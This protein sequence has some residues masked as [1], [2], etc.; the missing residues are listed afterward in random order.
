MKRISRVLAVGTMVALGVVGTSSSALAG[1][2][3]G[4]TPTPPPNPAKTAK[5]LQAHGA[6]VKRLGHHQYQIFVPAAQ[7]AEVNRYCKRYLPPGGIDRGGDSRLTFRIGGPGK[8]GS[9]KLEKCLSDH[10]APVPAGEPTR[11]EGSTSRSENSG[12]GDSGPEAGTVIRTT[13]GRSVTTEKADPETLAA[14]KACA[15]Y[16]PSPGPVTDSAN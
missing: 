1:S 14:L 2:G 12:S 8:A 10:G 4:G 15:A 16:L 13:D 7:A 9:A 5:C 11:I 6:Q 3:D